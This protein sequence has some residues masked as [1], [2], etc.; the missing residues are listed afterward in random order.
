M[1]MRSVLANAFVLP[2]RIARTQNQ[3]FTGRAK[4]TT[5]LFTNAGPTAFTE[6][7]GDSSARGPL[8]PH[9]GNRVELRARQLRRH[10]QSRV[11]QFAR[12]GFDP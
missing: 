12:A 3:R 7:I 9:V 2:I 8:L 6:P 4:Q 10:A 11:R 1:Y 5:S